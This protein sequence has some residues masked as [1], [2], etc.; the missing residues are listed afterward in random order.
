MPFY[1]YNS[2]RK[3]KKYVMIMPEFNHKH[4]FG[5][6]GMRDFTLINNKKSKFYISDETEREKV[7][8]AYQARHAKDNIDDVHSAGALS[9]HILWTQPTLKGG[10]KEYSKRFGVLVVDRT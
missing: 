7:K 8:N 2:N 6:K 1:L 3:D 10:I 4:H 9:W 5:S